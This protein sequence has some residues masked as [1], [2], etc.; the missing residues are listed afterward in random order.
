MDR[1]L[2]LIPVESSSPSF[3][4][5]A[6]CVSSKCLE[7]GVECIVI[8][9]Q[10]TDSYVPYTIAVMSALLAF[11]RGRNVARKLGL[12]VL[13]RIYSNRQISQVIDLARKTFSSTR[14]AVIVAITKDRDVNSSEL[15]SRIS[16]CNLKACE[17]NQALAIPKIDQKVPMIALTNVEL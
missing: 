6:Q 10:P 13:V 8:P 7:V 9:A 16:E 17:S 12:E 14:K 2:L 4:D 11:E 15:L 1:E 5:V 3:D